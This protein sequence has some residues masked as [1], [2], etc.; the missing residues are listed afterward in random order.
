MAGMI[1]A[2]SNMNTVSDSSTVMP[3]N[4]RV[5]RHISRNLLPHCTFLLNIDVEYSKEMQPFLL[6]VS[7]NGILKH[8]DI[9]SP[10]ENLCCVYNGAFICVLMNRIQHK[11]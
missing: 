8:A 5:D 6:L 2:T 10:G 1:S 9:F 4:K 7:L 11:C 3:A